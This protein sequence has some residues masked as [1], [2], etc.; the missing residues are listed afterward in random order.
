MF[1]NFFL[2]QSAAQARSFCIQPALYPSLLRRCI[3]R[4][5]E[6]SNE[7]TASHAMRHTKCLEVWLSPTDHSNQFPRF[8][9]L[10]CSLFLS[11]PH[12]P[13]LYAGLITSYPCILTST[14]LPSFFIFS[15]AAFTPS[16]SALVEYFSALKSPFKRLCSRYFGMFSFWINRLRRYSQINS[17][18]TIFLYFNTSL[19]MAISTSLA[20]SSRISAQ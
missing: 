20:T 13:L 11:T 10:L 3:T 18:K 19:S 7:L 1:G 2:N 6:L 9:V 5:C 15:I 14:L 16:I 8:H 17:T 4:S 12:G